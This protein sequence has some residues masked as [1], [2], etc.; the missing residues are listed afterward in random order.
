MAIS[1]FKAKCLSLL[2]EVHKTIKAILVTRFGKPVGKVIPPSAEVVAGTWIDERL[3][4][5][6]WGYRVSGER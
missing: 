2:D 3:D 5:S 1:K 6:P 4:E